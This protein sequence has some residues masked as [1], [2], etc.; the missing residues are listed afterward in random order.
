M[1]P[2]YKRLLKNI[3]IAALIVISCGA[4]FLVPAF[5]RQRD[6][7]FSVSCSN[8]FNFIRSA[9]EQ[10][11]QETSDA[12]LPSTTDTKAALLSITKYLKNVTWIIRGADVPR[13]F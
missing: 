2:Q 9:L 3:G 5:K 11:A 7:T 4:A 1:E 8:H 13:R 6:H 12:I 10:Q